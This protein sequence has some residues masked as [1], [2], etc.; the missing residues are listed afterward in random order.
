MPL[1]N[2]PGVAS[3][4]VSTVT[5]SVLLTYD[6]SRSTSEVILDL[7]RR[8]GYVQ[9]EAAGAAVRRAS[10]RAED[11]ALTAAPK[12]GQMVLSWAAER[13]LAAAVAALW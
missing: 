5:G 10:R 11:W 9:T 4:P 3:V 6:T 2:L 1:S 13:A 12:V 7:L 8:N